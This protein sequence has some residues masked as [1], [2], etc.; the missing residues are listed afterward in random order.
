MVNQSTLAMLSW[1]LGL[2]LDPNP[3]L[4]LMLQSGSKDGAAELWKHSCGCANHSVDWCIGS[5]CPL[6]QL[7]GGGG[8]QLMMSMKVMLVHS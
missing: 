4:Q 7:R 8:S 6:P 1:T 5:G 2:N 3:L